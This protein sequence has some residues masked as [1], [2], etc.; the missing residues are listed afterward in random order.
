M[1]A[2]SSAPGLPDPDLHP[3][4][5]SG[6]LPKRFI[7]WLVDLLIVAVIVA[8]AVLFTAFIGLFF[9]PVIWLTIDAA[10]RLITMTG[11]SATWGQRLMGV[12]FRDAYGKRFDLAQAGLH[13]TGY[14]VSMSF[15]IPQVISVVL[16]MA[17]SRGQGLADM[18]LGQ[19]A[20]NRPADRI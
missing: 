3:G 5:Y 20:I 16:M 1:T 10:Y 15:V 9:L 18:L 6:T 7:A 8:V 17:S 12:E 2:Y 13:V 4:F 14:L 11:R 19:A